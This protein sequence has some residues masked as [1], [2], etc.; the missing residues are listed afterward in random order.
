MAVNPLGGFGA[1]DPPE[2]LK[3][4]PVTNVFWFCTALSHC[5]VGAVGPLSVR[6][7]IE[8]FWK[9]KVLAGPGPCAPCDVVGMSGCVK[10]LEPSDSPT[11]QL[12][13]K[14]T[15]FLPVIVKGCPG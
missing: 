9:A 13:W 15:S 10:T 14:I 8:A 2:V 4:T 11:S 5:G 3:A 1:V 6:T 12:A 7:P